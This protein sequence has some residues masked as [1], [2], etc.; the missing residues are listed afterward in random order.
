MVS[1]H[2]INSNNHISISRQNTATVV[3]GIL[4]SAFCVIGFLT[5]HS[6]NTEIGGT[7]L[8]IIFILLSIVM[9]ILI[10]GLWHILDFV[11]K[12]HLKL[13]KKIESSFFGRFIATRPTLFWILVQIVLLAFWLPVLLASWPGFFCYDTEVLT[14]FYEGKYYTEHPL[15]YTALASNIII[16]LGTA[17]GSINHGVT[18]YVC[19]TA[20]IASSVLC[21]LVRFIAKEGYLA[22][23]IASF[24]FYALNPLVVM[25]SL[26]TAKDVLS[27]LLISV[28]FLLIILVAQDR[29]RLDSWKIRISLVA[30]IFLLCSL[31]NNTI[32]ALLILLPILILA[33]GEK[34]KTLLL[35]YGSGLFLYLIW[36]F[37]ISQCILSSYELTDKH[38]LL[39][40]NSVPEQQLAFAWNDGNLTEEEKNAFTGVINPGSES[41]LENARYDDADVARGAFAQSLIDKR[42]LRSFY[43]LYIEEGMRHPGAYSK[44]FLSLTYEAWY[45]LSTPRGYNGG[46]DTQFD[47]DKTTTSL[48]GC[49]IEPPAQL[50]S[51]FPFLYEILWKVS[52]FDTLQSNPLTAWLISIPFFFWLLLITLARGIVQKRTDTIAACSLLVAI[53]ITFLFGPMVLPRYYLCLFYTA[54]MLVYCALQKSSFIKQGKRLPQS[55]TRNPK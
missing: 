44:A 33:F 25:F 32:I 4:F 53:I 12:H 23:S 11:E 50:N 21:A 46:W 18:I 47:Y 3:L 55:I 10:H 27:S 45:P 13:D 31:R 20:I 49:W 2:S 9:M 19:M 6:F 37:P 36:A 22:L 30:L 16:N 39:L 40:I 5:D 26:C 54:P 43:S 17:L 42:D 1:L 24:A 34:K 51:K 28:L 41:M 29:N 14:A 7:V 52:R 38:D 8:F 35:C 15:M 48:F